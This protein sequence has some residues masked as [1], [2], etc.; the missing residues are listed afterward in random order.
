MGK[1]YQL[2]Y[3]Y[4]NIARSK[5]ITPRIPK[6]CINITSKIISTFQTPTL[7]KAKSIYMKIPIHPNRPR[8]LTNRSPSGCGT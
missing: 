3:C 1:M 7:L 4:A 8:T 5:G 6:Q 2:K